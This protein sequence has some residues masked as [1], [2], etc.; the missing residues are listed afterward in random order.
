MRTAWLVAAVVGTVGLGTSRPAGADVMTRLDDAWPAVPAVQRLSLDDQLADR[1]SDFGNSI[2]ARLDAMS[3]DVVA[4]RFDVRAQRAWLRIRGG[5]EHL[6]IAMD[7]SWYFADGMAHVSTTL[8]VT[9][10]HRELYVELP[11]FEMVPT[12][13]NG[14]RYVEWRV[15]VIDRKF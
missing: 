4:M 2:G 13:F 8:D 6:K 3:R 5:G 14:E 15:P 10:G 7:T 1:F 9:L 11:S 12:S